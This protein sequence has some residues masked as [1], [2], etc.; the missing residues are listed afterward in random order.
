MTLTSHQH[1]VSFRV[2]D[3]L[4]VAG[5]NGQEAFSGHVVR[6][7]CLAQLQKGRCQI[8]HVDEVV[9]DPTSRELPLPHDCQGDLDSKVVEVAFAVGYPRHA[10]IPTDHHHRIF[11]V[12]S[13]TQF[14]Q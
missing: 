3:S 6:D 1:V 11:K 12:S 8:G 13:F 4:L 7:R 2:D 5:Q 10:M 14:L 9:D